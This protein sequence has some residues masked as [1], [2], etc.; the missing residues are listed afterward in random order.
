[1]IIVSYYISEIK[2]GKKLQVSYTASYKDLECDTT[3]KY[4][5]VR[6]SVPE[7]V[8]LGLNNIECVSTG[9]CF[10]ERVTVTDCSK[11]QKRS[12]TVTTA[13]ID[14]SL[15]CDPASRKSGDIF[16]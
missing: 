6:K 9:V 4:T 12:T 14:V 1:M 8:Q 2:D 16:Q 10:P 3:D 11:R 13:G 7:T 5:D 15:S